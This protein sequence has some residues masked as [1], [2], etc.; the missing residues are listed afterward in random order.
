MEFKIVEEYYPFAVS[1]CGKV[2]NIKTGNILKSRLCH[3]GYEFVSTSCKIKKGDYRKV[4]AKVHRLIAI[5]YIPNPLGKEQVNHI[6]GIKHDNSIDNLE[7]C[8]QSENIRHAL[9][10]GLKPYRS[11]NHLVGEDAWNTNLTDET[12]HEICR[13]MVNGIRDH[14]LIKEY[15][16]PHML[17]YNLRN[18]ITW[19]HIS[20]DYN[21]P[22]IE[23]KRKIP[24][25][26]IHWLCKQI[27]EGKTTRQITKSSKN[28]K[29]DARVVGACRNK[30][31]YRDI[32]DQYF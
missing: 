28:K 18:G 3:K 19:K 20:K 13:K 12:V 5:A 14:V 10:T 21:F 31:V 8:T 9:D 23:V 30:R 24:D 6:N 27:S 16:L 29:I 4:S 25:E 17:P 7:W 2:K 15:N 11:P 26:D 22:E 32:S 1:K